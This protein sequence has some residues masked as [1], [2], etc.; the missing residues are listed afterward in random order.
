MGGGNPLKKV[1]K[2]AT[3][4]VATPYREAARAVGADG[5]VKGI[6]GA[7]DFATGV[8][9]G[10]IDLANNEKGKQQKKAD[11]ANAES[12]GIARK[13][14][15]AASASAATA[16]TA[17]I[18]GDRMNSGSKSRTLLTGPAGLDDEEENK[19]ISRRTL[20]GV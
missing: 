17:R 1:I 18:E 7:Q 14:A 11:A 15:A 2:E 12:D 6:Q 3:N 19:S 4:L 8:G 13:A 20:S 5:L 9:V 10:G 16:E